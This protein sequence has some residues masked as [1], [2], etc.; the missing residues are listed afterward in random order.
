MAKVPLPDRG[1]PLDVTYMYQLATAINDVSDSISTA[2]GKYATIDTR[3]IGRQTFKIQDI[4]IFAGYIE[5]ANTTTVSPTTTIEKSVD[6]G[7]SFAYPPIV[8][9]TIINNNTK[10]AGDDA[11]VV[12]SSTTTSSASF[13]VRFATTGEASVGI[14]YIAIGVPA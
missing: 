9:A 8:I 4:R 14:N 5:A 2:T 7:V 10:A 3:T 13:R 1:Q 11:T 6:F 12:V